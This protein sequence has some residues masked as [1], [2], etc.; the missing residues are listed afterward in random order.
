MTLYVAARYTEKGRARAIRAALVN[1]GYAVSSRWLYAPETTPRLTAA[2]ECLE[3]I[4][5]SH[6]VVL[7]EPPLLTMSKDLWER[8]SPSLQ[9]RFGAGGG[10]R[11]IEVGYALARR[12]PILVLDAH[13][14]TAG[15]DGRA[16]FWSLPQVTVFPTLDQLLCALPAL[17]FRQEEGPIA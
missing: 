13:P 11:Y 12:M 2:L 16:V 17:A 14:P 4:R 5:R 1:A 10:G 3:D 9:D 15:S 8:L 6:A 7:V